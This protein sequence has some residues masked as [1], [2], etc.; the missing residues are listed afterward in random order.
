MTLVGTVL[1]LAR[2]LRLAGRPAKPARGSIATSAPLAT[3]DP[4][5][6]VGPARPVGRDP[7]GLSRWQAERA[8]YRLAALRLTDRRPVQAVLHAATPDA[9]PHLRRALAAG[10]PAAQVLALAGLLADRPAGWAAQRL[11]LLDDDT[12]TQWRFG[13]R[14]DQVDG[15]TCGTTVLL[16]LAAHADPLLALELTAPPHDD[17]GAGFG[18][19]WDRRQRAVHKQSNRV[20]PAAMGTSPWGMV[21]WL[22]RH[23]PGVGPYRVR[24]MDD[25][26]AADVADVLGKVDM[27]LAWGA[28]VPLLVGAQVPRHYTLALPGQPSARGWRVFDPSNGEVRWVPPVAVAE[29][30]LGPLLGFDHLHGVLLPRW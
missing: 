13:V 22:R 28:A 25:A 14:I 20:W 23:A 2:P 24:L 15:T 6:P 5:S 10:R 11:R 8:E 3:P 19:R 1:R 26:S 21:A 9:R 30:R 4:S 17:Q 7:D 29:R 18:A 16:V 27:A 12:G